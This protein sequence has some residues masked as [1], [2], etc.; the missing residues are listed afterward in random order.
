MI[1]ETPLLLALTPVLA[2]LFG[3]VAWLARRRRVR[4]ADAWSRGLGRSARGRLRRGWLL[5]G[6][7]ALFAGVALAGPRAGR[8]RVSTETQSLNLVLAVDISRSMLAEDARPNRLQRAVRESRRLVQDLAGDRLGVIAFAGRSYI[9]T[10]LTVDGSAVRMYLD[11]LD[12][13]LASEGGSSLAAV[14]QQGGQLLAAG[15]DGADRVLVVFT[16][17]EAHDSLPD[18]IAAA[19]ALRTRGVR[20]VRSASAA[21]MTSGSES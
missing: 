10:P 9:L 11:G 13:D 3:V 12:P 7:A 5:A 4:L 1:F 20:L 8:A 16:D 14:L 2:L 18:V 19:E 6:L 15:G 21:A 17:G